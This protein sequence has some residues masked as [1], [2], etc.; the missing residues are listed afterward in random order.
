[1][2]NHIEN[3]IK[4]QINQVKDFPRVGINFLDFTPLLTENFNLCINSL[5]A[6]VKHLDFTHIA[7]I[8]ARGFILGGGMAY[9]LNKNFVPVRKKG[10]TPSPKS[11]EY[12]DLEY[13]KDAVE[14][15]INN[16]FNKV[17][18]VDDVLATGGTLKASNGVLQKAGYDVVG[19][20]V[21]INIKELNNMDDVLSVVNY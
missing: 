18:I 6:K 1:M 2:N 3:L 13:G 15:Q 21:L 8:D 9:A 5:C 7:G 11:I 4:D 19:S 16:D 12:Y 17:L 20:L 14:C 10:K